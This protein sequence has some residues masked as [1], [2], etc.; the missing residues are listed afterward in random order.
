MRCCDGQDR[1]ITGYNLCTTSKVTGVT[2]WQGGYGVSIADL[3]EKRGFCREGKPVD[4]R[5]EA[6]LI[7]LLSE[8][9][10]NSSKS[11][12]NELVRIAVLH[13]HADSAG[14]RLEQEGAL[15]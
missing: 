8:T 14:I 6:A 5:A 2:E 3:D 4:P 15:P 9:A 12:L 1:H 11:A 10:A 13:Y 7:A